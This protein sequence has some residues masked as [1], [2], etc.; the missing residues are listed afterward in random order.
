MTKKVPFDEHRFSSVF[1]KLYN[2]LF[3]ME[4]SKYLPP[5]FSTALKDLAKDY[6]CFE[7]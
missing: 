1:I 5:K 6:G 4:D 7:K 2:R 3:M